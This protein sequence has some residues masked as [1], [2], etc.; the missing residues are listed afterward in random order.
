MQAATGRSHANIFLNDRD[1]ARKQAVL[2]GLQIA[3]AWGFGH[4]YCALGGS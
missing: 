1:T 4:H 3:K 2:I